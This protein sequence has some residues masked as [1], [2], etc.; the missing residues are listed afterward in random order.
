MILG[1]QA[2]IPEIRRKHDEYADKVTD[3]RVLHNTCKG[4]PQTR[5]NR[6]TKPR[7]RPSDIRTHQAATQTKAVARGGQGGSADPTW[8]CLQVNFGGKA[9]LI[10]MMLVW[11]VPILEDGGNRPLELYKEPPHTLSRQYTTFI[12]S[13]RIRSSSRTPLVSLE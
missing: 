9:D 7:H 6:P 3:D 10:L 12:H 1:L 11:H 5:P 2:P 8:K 4:G 13:T